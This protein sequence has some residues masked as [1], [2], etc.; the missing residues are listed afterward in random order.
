MA[1]DR[2][3]EVIEK[4]LQHSYTYDEY[5]ELI[6]N[7]LAEGK[8]TGHVQ[9]EDL[10]NY[11]VLNER[12]M[13]RWDKTVTIDKA[14]IEK[15]TQAKLNITW[16]VITE[17]WCGDAAHAL[18]IIHKIAALNPGIEL[19]LVLRDD[20]E[21]LMHLFLTNGAKS[22]PKL[23]SYA[24]DSK[25]VLATWGPRPS[26]ATQL[27]EAYKAEHGSLDPVFKQELQM[28]YNRNKG[29]NIAEDLAKLI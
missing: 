13:K 7:L 19:R 29:K 2:K 20:N 4:A 18:P 25:E 1:S 27:V 10:Y 24:T 6:K 26:E 22:I 23:I 5:K 16:L 8:S 3:I 14:I 17:G 9:T 28:W 11:S 12:R 15:A 21:D